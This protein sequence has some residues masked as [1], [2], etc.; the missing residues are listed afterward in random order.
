M[1]HFE[2]MLYDQALFILAALD[3]FQVTGDPDFAAMARETVTYLLRDLRTTEGAFCCGEDADSEGVEGT[4]YLWT[5][6]QVRAALPADL[7]DL[8]CRAY[9]ITSRGNFA[10][11]SIPTLVATPA[12]LAAGRGGTEEESEPADWSRSGCSC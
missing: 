11:K 5:P 9:G 4:F 3:G 12:E 8:A 6:A 2:K 7:A 1:P 10:G